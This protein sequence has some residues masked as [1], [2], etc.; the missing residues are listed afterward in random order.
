VIT[1]FNTDVEHN[2]TT[3]HVQTE[4][5]GL[6]TPFIL[7]LVYDGGTILASRRQP[8]DDLFTGGF[9][10]KDLAARLQRQHNLICA[11][12][13]AGRIGDLKA[14]T[15]GNG[16]KE[17]LNRPGK[18][19]RRPAKIEVSEI[20]A[21]PEVAPASVPPAEEAATP[22]RKEEV[23]PL[24]EDVRVIDEP[25]E[26]PEEA[27]AVVSDMAGKERPGHN[28]LCL[29][30]VNETAVRGGERKSV[31]FMLSRGS[32]RKVV[33][34]AKILVKILGSN[35]RPQIFHSITD[36]NGLAR[37]DLEVPEFAG[38]R[39][40]FLVRAAVDGDEVE[41]RRPILQT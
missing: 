40:A 36:K 15:N 13:S 7:T 20:A 16:K 37:M 6:E 32:E 21:P 25:V 27:V 30:F 4:D 34:N 23:L 29:E 11:A 24:I 5:K 9:R 35:I 14:S 12:I 17:K 41:L 1:G 10:E 18:P 33:G 22:E 3:Y 26:V 8:Y 2:G 38:G 31:T 19:K 28:K 39:A